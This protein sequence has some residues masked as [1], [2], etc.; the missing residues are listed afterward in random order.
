G[1]FCLGFGIVLAATDQVTL[2]P[3]AARALE[4]KQNS[5]AQVIPAAIHDNNPVKDTLT[6]KGHGGKD[7]TI[8]RAIKAGKVTGVAYE[9]HGSG[10]A[11]EMKLMLGVDAEGKVLGVRALAHK[12]TPGLGD[13]INIAK[14]DWITRFN[15]LSLGAPPV[16]KWKVKKD[17][18]QFDQFSGATITPRGVV[19]AIR[20]GLEFYAHNKTSLLEVR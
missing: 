1:A 18:G 20:E 8:Y 4:D 7:V 2:E 3:I 5:L 6:L 15:G 9:I 19:K 14:G 16:D 17:G 13:K 10:Y 11:G 12:E